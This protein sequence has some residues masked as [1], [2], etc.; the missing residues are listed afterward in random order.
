MTDERT[1]LVAGA[2]GRQGG[3]VARILL[4]RGYR[5]RALTRKPNSSA[6]HRLK[7]LGAE[8]RAGDLEARGSVVRAAEGADALFAVSTP[9][10]AGIEAEVR[11]GMALAE[12]AKEAEVGHL[13]YSSAASADRNTGI[14]HFESKYAVERHIALLG[15]PS[16]VIGPVAFFENVVSPWRLP[17]LQKGMLAATL[18]PHRQVQQIAVADIGAFA[19]LVLERREEFLGRRVD[20]ASERVNGAEQAEILSRVTGR[21]IRY[22]ELPIERRGRQ[23]DTN[24]SVYDADIEGLRHEYPEVGWHTFESWATEQDWR[25]LDAQEATSAS[26]RTTEGALEPDPAEGGEGSGDLVR[27]TGRGPGAADGG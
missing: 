18:P 12:A 5:V 1:V 16:T 20:I 6:A 22:V 24:R 25:V 21:K 4:A 3:A 8:V 17:G 15:I 7:R 13:V 19:A 27:Q 14:P 9:F 11:Q 10:E 23:G 26:A 2:T